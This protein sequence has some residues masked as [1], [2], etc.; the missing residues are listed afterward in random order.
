MRI[1]VVTYEF[2]PVGGGGG[3]AAF[4]ICQ[5]LAK[6]GH[7]VHVLTAHMKGLGHQESVDGYQVIR[8]SSLRR[9]SYKADLP[10]MGGFIVAG[11]WAGL[12]HI[13]SWRPDI[14]HVHFA[15]PTG[16]V[17]WLLSRITGVPYVLTAHLGDIP[18][19]VPNKTSGWFRW[20]YPFTPRLWQDAAQVVAVSEYSRQLALEHY[21]IDIKVIPNGVNLQA[22]NPGDI[23]ISDPPQIVF[24]GRFMQQKNPVTLV[25]IL[26]GLQNLDWKCAMLG[27]G[28]LR[29][30]VEQ[31]IE[32]NGLR[33]RFVIPGWVTP[34][35]VI[36]YF[37]NSDILLMPS[38]SE[39][40]PVVGVQALAMGLA[41]VASRVGG[42]VDIVDQGKNGF[43]YSQNDSEGMQSGLRELIS[44]KETLLV[45]RRHSREFAQRFDISKVVDEYVQIFDEVAKA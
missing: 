19:G 33:D 36:E 29:E 6:R 21:P 2:P 5:A 43:L 15:V 26:A 18:G 44:D 28:S 12:R 3:R 30:D 24:A 16:P 9:S 31:E 38:S 11:L 17:A 14:I 40:L 7:E 35:E 37:S 45:F 27:D 10:A 4:D 39:G 13:R 1:L 25:R 22:L 32:R 20:I 41:I 42:F 8:I 23:Q 34:E